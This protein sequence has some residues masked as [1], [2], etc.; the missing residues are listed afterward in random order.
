MLISHLKI[1]ISNENR[2]LSTDI[3][4]T[5]LPKSLN[6]LKIGPFTL[7]LKLTGHYD[8]AN[9]PCRTC[10]TETSNSRV[11]S[12]LIIYIMLNKCLNIVW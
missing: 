1:K 5:I 9:C 10:R 7:I 6:S 4:L 11:G 3:V 8:N 2:R 12:I